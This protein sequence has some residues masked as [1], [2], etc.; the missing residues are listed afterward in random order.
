MPAAGLERST[1]LILLGLARVL[2]ISFL[3]PLF[4]KTLCATKKKR[5]SLNVCY[6]SHVES[7]SEK[8]FGRSTR[9]IEIAPGCSGC[10]G[11]EKVY[12]SSE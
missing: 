3:N 8:K 10:G 9:G 5:E 4:A 2:F 11:G 1:E 7:R 12:V 6:M